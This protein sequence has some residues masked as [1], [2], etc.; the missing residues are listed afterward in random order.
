[1]INSYFPMILLL[2][3]CAAFLVFLNVFAIG[4]TYPSTVTI[5]VFCSS[6]MPPKHYNTWLYLMGSSTCLISRGFMRMNV[7]L[8]YSFP[9]CNRFLCWLCL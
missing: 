6:S 2:Y 5:E 4:I 8:D 9:D 7:D 1:M 3:S